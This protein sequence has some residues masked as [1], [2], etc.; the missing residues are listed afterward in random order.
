MKKPGETL[1][2]NFGQ[3]P[4]SFDIDAMVAAE[5]AAIMADISHVVSRPTPSRITDEKAFLHALVGQYLAHDGYVET[6]RAFAEEVKD[7]ARAL[8]NEDDADVGY[9][10][11]EEDLDAI[12]RQKIRAAILE[13]DIDK[14]LKHT[15][16]YY[17]SVL[18]D[19]E[20]IYFKLRCRKFIEMIRRCNELNAQCHAPTPP[21][22]RSTTSNGF[23]N[24]ANTDDYDFEMEL[25]EQ[26]GVHNGAPQLNI[27]SMDTEDELEDKEAKL[28]ELTDETI[29]YGQDLKKE[30][31]HD[32]R[33]EVKRALEDT[34]ALI[35]YETASNSP[36]ASLLE[37]GGRVPV[38]EELNSAI[39]G[40]FTNT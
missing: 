19:N 11:A 28:S 12:N 2:A 1:R 27:D 38:A 13:G 31:A 14:A 33:R 6:A 30:F 34:F 39:L 8:A 15:N 5:K 22:K 7:E 20:N 16:A 37:T 36:L 23:S 18:R 40:I 9:A 21:S 32:P 26:L 17:P 35:A 3:E 24:S 4:F 25:D 10:E 29:R